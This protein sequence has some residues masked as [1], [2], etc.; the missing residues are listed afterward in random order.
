MLAICD[1]ANSD[2][3]GDANAKPINHITHP[4]TA[5]ATR[6]GICGD[7]NALNPGCQAYACSAIHISAGDK[8]GTFCMAAA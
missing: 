4:T 8:I 5:D 7:F 1:C 2:A 3:I 6:I